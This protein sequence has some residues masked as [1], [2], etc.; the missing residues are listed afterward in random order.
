V[1]PLF[2]GGATT[3]LYGVHHPPTV[4]RRRDAG[5]VLCYPAV[6]EYNRSHWAFRKLAGLLARRGFH[7]LRFDYSGTGDSA[8]EPEQS[9][10]RRW[11]ADIREAAAEL[12]ALAEVRRVSLVGFRLG[13][14]LAALAS[15][16]F[17]VRDLVLWEPAVDGLEHIRDLR[18]IQRWKLGLTSNPPR[19]GPREL[20]GYS[21]PPALQADIGGIGLDDLSGCRAERVLLYAGEERPAYRRLAARL[22]DRPD[23]GFRFELVAE[24]PAGRLDGVLLSTRIQEAIAEGLG[25]PD[26]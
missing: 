7:V 14:A 8:G 9:S 25:G 12:T 5:I 1:E 22:G 16:G 13:G 15:T 3:P 19:V 23:G 21:F 17:E 18:G 20:L 24:E 10:V 11:C 2:F 6:Q 26:S 4:R